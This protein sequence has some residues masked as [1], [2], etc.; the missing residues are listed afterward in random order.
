MSIDLHTHTNFSDGSLSPEALV[1]LALKKKIEVLAITDHD[2]VG[3]IHPAMQHSNNFPIEI[4]AGVELSI[5]YQLQ[6]LGHLHILVLFI[7]YNNEELITNL[8]KLKQARYD[9]IKIMVQKVKAL[10]FD[11]DVNE[12]EKYVGQGSAGRPHLARILVEKDIVKDIPDAFGKYLS[13][14][15]PAY[16]P[17]T[18]LSAQAAIDLI[19][20]AGG[21]AI[22]A[23]PYSLGYATYPEMG[24]EILKLKAMGLDGLEAYYTSYNV[25]LTNWLL[26]F[27]K[28]NNMLI[29]GGSDFHGEPKPEIQLGSGSG[30]L[31]IPYSVYEKLINYINY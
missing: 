14:G 25:Y 21:L 13:K 27:A 17:K 7:D 16:V 3:A 15:R 1:D 4:V 8:D 6:G 12:L 31:S 9:R 10:G 18:K 28:E 2:E 29:S 24:R 20:H 5:E 19:H 11:L 26:E 23:H 30:N 22:I